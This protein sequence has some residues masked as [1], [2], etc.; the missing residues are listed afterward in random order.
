[1]NLK[2]WYNQ[3]IQNSKIEMPRYINS[4]GEEV[5][6]TYNITKVLGMYNSDIYNEKNEGK[7]HRKVKEADAS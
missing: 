6:S 4:F 2:H 1:M 7:I 3:E 5:I